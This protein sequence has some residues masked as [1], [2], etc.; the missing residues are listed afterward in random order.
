MSVFL[1]EIKNAKCSFIDL[2][3]GQTGRSG[4]TGTVT[5]VGV[6]GGTT[7]L[8]ATGGPITASG[9][10]LGGTLLQPNGGTGATTGQGQILD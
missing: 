9:I 7:G 4:G 5:S 2:Q 6:S 10:T 3:A 8:T 1:Q